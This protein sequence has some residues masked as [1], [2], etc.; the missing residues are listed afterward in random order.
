M[1]GASS[2]HGFTLIE[3][4]VALV[5]LAIAAAGIIRAAEAHVDTI[6]ALEKRTA[7]RWVAENTMAEASLGIAG[8]DQQAMLNWNWSARTASSPSDDPDLRQVSVEVLEAGSTSPLVT[9]RG[10]ADAGT[11]TK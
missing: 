4:M 5:I 3:A 6:H 8:P 11:T 1:T 9:L 7:A 2:E 10:F